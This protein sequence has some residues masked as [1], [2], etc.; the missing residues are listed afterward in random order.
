MTCCIAH[1]GFYQGTMVEFN[2][3]LTVTPSFTKVS[4]S[5]LYAYVLHVTHIWN[6][7]NDYHSVHGHVKKMPKRA[8]YDESPVLAS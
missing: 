3:F 6:D 7:I 4:R 8:G 1:M 5:S 2:E